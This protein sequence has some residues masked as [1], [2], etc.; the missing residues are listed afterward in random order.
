MEKLKPIVGSG[1]VVI[2]GGQI[3]LV[4]GVGSVGQAQ[5]VVGA[6]SGSV[7]PLVATGEVT[8]VS[9]SSGVN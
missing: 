8:R 5:K 7:S 3:T 4:S 1:S 2:V 9:G 6:G